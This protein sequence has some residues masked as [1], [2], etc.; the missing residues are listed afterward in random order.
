MQQSTCISIRQNVVHICVCVSDSPICIDWLSEIFRFVDYTIW[1]LTVSWKPTLFKF[2]N[3]SV[4]RRLQLITLHVSR[5]KCTKRQFIFCAQ[6]KKHFNIN[7]TSITERTTANWIVH[8]LIRQ[9]SRLMKNVRTHI[10]H[11]TSSS[12]PAYLFATINMNQAVTTSLKPANYAYRIENE[13]I[14]AYNGCYI[15]WYL[16]RNYDTE[17]FALLKVCFLLVHLKQEIKCDID[18]KIK[19]SLKVK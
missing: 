13:S 16:R 11:T 5:R 7:D 2:S 18:G 10:F 9:K 19:R 14:T 8:S 1:H 3:K 15:K 4:E 6:F 12:K 17:V